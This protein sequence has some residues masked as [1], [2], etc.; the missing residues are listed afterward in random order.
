MPGGAEPVKSCWCFFLYLR[1]NENPQQD[2]KWGMMCS[3]VQRKFTW[4]QCGELIEWDM[5]SKGLRK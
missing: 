3:D 2:M 1:G 5:G 4:L